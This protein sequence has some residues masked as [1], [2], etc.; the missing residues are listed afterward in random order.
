M[1]TNCV[2][3]TAYVLKSQGSFA[4][5]RPR[6]SLGGAILAAQ[7]PFR[8]AVAALSESA[9]VQYA[10][11]K[12]IFDCT[13]LGPGACVEEPHLRL[14]WLLVNA[15]F[16][17]AALG[18]REHL[19]PIAA[20]AAW[21][22]GSRKRAEIAITTFSPLS[23]RA[24]DQALTGVKMDQK[25]W[26]LY[27][28]VIEPQGHVSRSCLQKEDARKVR[29][30]KK[31]DGVY[32]TPSDV[33]DFMV[34]QLAGEAEIRGAWIDPACGT[35]VFLRSII[36]HAKGNGDYP[37]RGVNM[38]Q[39]HVYGIDKSAL[40]TDSCAFVMLAELE[41]DDFT[42]TTPFDLWRQ[43]KQNV[44]CMDALNLRPGKQVG[45]LFSAQLSTR[46][47]SSLF[48][49]SAAIGIRYLVM[50]PP[51]AISNG[52]DNTWGSWLALE[53]GSGARA[54][55]H[56]A[57]TEMMWGLDSIEAAA[58]VLPLSIATNTTRTYTMVRNA[59]VGSSGRK[60]MLFFDREP[61]ALFGED[62]KTRN[63][64]L[65]HFARQEDSLHTSQLLK[66]TAPQRETIFTRERL[67]P[68]QLRL[69]KNFVPK[70]GST[71]EEHA[72]DQLC[73]SHRHPLTKYADAVARRTLDQLVDDHSDDPASISIGSTGYN[74][75]NVFFS[76]ELAK[77][78]PNREPRSL[79][80]TI[81]LAFP[82]EEM[83]LAAYALLASRLSFWMWRVEGDGFHVTSDFIKRLPLWILLAD[84]TLR[85]DLAKHG[86]DIRV[87]SNSSV[88]RSV[89]RGR[90]T[91]S[92]HCGFDRASSRRVEELALTRL[93]GTTMFSY[94][95]DR[96]LHAV[97]SIDGK[98]RRAVT[99]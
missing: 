85:G 99:I 6:R 9:K 25:L 46:C 19:S 86:R 68:V 64:I 50:N 48:P 12:E 94:E 78:A 54:E 52:Q 66:W 83:A 81:F 7:K 28:Y 82:D 10:Q 59:Y 20:S 91:Y 17:H 21:F 33:A 80:P 42:A 63:A 57:F 77:F 60:E 38:I 74:Y 14:A 15:C 75:L 29:K 90:E 8:A 40:A 37:R 18:Q 67:V 35:G 61:Q 87:A 5:P 92:F 71:A 95:L 23:I 70:L 1:L 16:V 2:A 4:K 47:L 22:F 27:P 97:T 55:L 53:G 31:A 73:S 76:S 49:S 89:N 51:Y 58:A 11:V 72:Y 79:S 34:S 65:F 84:E 30:S 45:D 24:A 36:T 39:D 93:L 98:M 62:I 13:V 3:S 88:T 26:D 41:L 44:A 32:Y 56:L 69:C 96:I 43:L